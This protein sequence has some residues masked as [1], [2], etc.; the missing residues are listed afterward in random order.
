MGRRSNNEGS[1]YKDEK[2]NRYIGQFRYVD[3]E[4][5]E[6]K[7][8][9]ITGTKK[10]EV[11]AAGRAFCEHNKKELEE[12]Q[13]LSHVKSL[14]NYMHSWL[15]RTVK[16]TIRQKTFERYESNFR[17]HIAPNIGEK[18]IRDINRVL[19]QEFFAG[20]R[21][22]DGKPLAARTINSIRN[23]L[24]AAFDAA[25]ADELVMKN[26]V[27]LTKPKKTEK[28]M[29]NVFNESQYKMLLSVAKRHSIKAYLVI[30]IA[31]ATGFRIGEIF[32]LEYSDVDFNA[33]T[34]RVRQ[35]V[36]STKHGKQLQQLAKNDSSL[37]TIKVER[38]LIDELLKYKKI[39]EIFKR[40]NGRNDDKEF[41]IENIDGSFCDPAYFTDKIFKKQLIRDAGLSNK[42][43]MHDCR[44]THATWL[45][46]KGVNIKIVSERL[47]HK[48]IRITLDI[49]SHVT[50]AMQEQAVQAL[51]GIL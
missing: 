5:G 15:E 16:P 41:I 46:E 18:D 10:S 35:T 38:A 31:F 40:A 2:L 39:H 45:I 13:A 34:L 49:Y 42:F 1:V 11:I 22:K 30:R 47:G 12:K 37:R 7:R 24:H 20:L 50:K 23:L 51:E 8:K 33:N 26:P 25:V 36:I 43:R 32:G 27:D 6:K 29:I 48:S 44:H 28:T 17:C 21:R 19:L 9:K 3:P 4:T 14:G